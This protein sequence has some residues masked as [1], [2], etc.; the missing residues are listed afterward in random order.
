MTTFCDLETSPAS[1]KCLKCAVITPIGPGHERLVADAE[2]SVAAAARANPGPF[3]EVLFLR[4]PD[5][6]GMHGRSR[7]RNEGIDHALAK[8][9]DWIF[10]LDADDLMALDAFASVGHY[11]QDYDGVFG[12]IA[13]S[14]IGS[15]YVT[16]R[17]KQLGPTTNIADILRHDP[18]LTLQ[19]GHFVRTKAAA[20]ILFDVNMDPGEDFKYYLDLWKQF[21]CAKIDRFFFV[22]RRGAHSTGPRSANGAIWRKAVTQVFEEFC[23]RHSLNT[24][25]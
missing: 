20:A 21:R 16:L 14:K 24:A 25:T 1:A 15:G 10:F 5:L 4:M 12:L 9:I 11:I 23:S 18:F 3:N 6:E 7:C 8:G 13:E 19:M 17:P 2:A 22:N